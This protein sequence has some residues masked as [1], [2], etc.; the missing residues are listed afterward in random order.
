MEEVKR[1]LVELCSSMDKFVD[2]ETTGTISRARTVDNENIYVVVVPI[3]ERSPSETSATS[4][5]IPYAVQV[6][7][8]STTRGVDHPTGFRFGPPPE[9]AT[10]TKFLDEE[11]A[12]IRGEI[13]VE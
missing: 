7:E 11:E 2:F 5:S 4:E 1:L 9:T 13:K 10:M 6:D 12:G 8:T 3:P